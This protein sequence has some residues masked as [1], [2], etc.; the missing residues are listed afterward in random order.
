MVV[1]AVILLVLAFI[2]VCLGCLRCVRY[3]ALPTLTEDWSQGQKKGKKRHEEDFDS[4]TNDRASLRR[5]V[6]GRF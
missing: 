3:S 5:S 4:A 1:V 2:A 6:D